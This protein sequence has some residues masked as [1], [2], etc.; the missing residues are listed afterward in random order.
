MCGRVVQG[1]PNCSV[2]T[3]KL[4]FKESLKSSGCSIRIDATEIY[5][6]FLC[7]DLEFSV[8]FTENNK[9]KYKNVLKRKKLNMLYGFLTYKVFKKCFNL[10][11]NCPRNKLIC[12]TIKQIFHITI[13]MYEVA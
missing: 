2:L 7:L 12:Q 10:F 3:H 4:C 6:H 13:H 11:S 9:Y 1:V 8:Y 5:F